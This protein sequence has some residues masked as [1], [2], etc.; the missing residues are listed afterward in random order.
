MGKIGEKLLT[1]PQHTDILVIGLKE[2]GTLSIPKLN[3][4]DNM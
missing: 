2:I 3:I 1:G 4:F